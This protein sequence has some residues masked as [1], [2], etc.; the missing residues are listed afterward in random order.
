MNICVKGLIA[1][2]AVTLLS[3]AAPRHSFAGSATWSASPST[4][5][6]NT[7][8]NWMPNTVPNGPGDVATLG[9]SDVTDLSVNTTSRGS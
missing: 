2:I 8:V 9:M 3:L 7:A 6:W 5:N 1:T 4:G